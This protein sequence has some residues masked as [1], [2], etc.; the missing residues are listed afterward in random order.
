ML[1]KYSVSS[2]GYD[3]TADDVT[4]TADSILTVL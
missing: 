4:A 1:A 2:N 3:V